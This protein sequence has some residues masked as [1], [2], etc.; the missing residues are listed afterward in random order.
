M[1]RGLSTLFYPFLLFST[2]GVSPF[3]ATVMGQSVTLAWDLNDDPGV[4]RYG[5]ESGVHPDG[6]LGFS[7]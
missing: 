5:R 2:L 3:K 7:A 1:I 4:I 6:I